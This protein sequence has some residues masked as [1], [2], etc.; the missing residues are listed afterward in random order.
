MF[1]F[2]DNAR[3]EIILE[4]LVDFMQETSGD[5]FDIKNILKSNAAAYA[6]AAADAA[7]AVA[8]AAAR[9]NKYDFFADQLIKILSE[10]K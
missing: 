7:A 2:K 8:A 6:A 3:V 4:R 1:S 10:L 9:R 5:I